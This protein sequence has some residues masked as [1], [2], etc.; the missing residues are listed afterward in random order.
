MCLGKW[1]DHF[2]GTEQSSNWLFTASIFLLDRERTYQTISSFPRKIEKWP[3]SSLKLL[4]VITCAEFQKIRVQF[5]RISIQCHGTSTCVKPGKFFTRTLLVLH[6]FQTILNPL[7]VVLEYTDLVFPFFIRLWTNMHLS[8][9][10]DWIWIHMHFCCGSLDHFLMIQNQ[11]QLRREV[12]SYHHSSC[13]NFKWIFNDQPQ[14]EIDQRLNLYE[15][16]FLPC[17][18]ILDILQAKMN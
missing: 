3:V 18:G 17:D 2:V 8:L 7:F 10:H 9:T 15:D 11:Y 12:T 13:Q 14:I 1:D 4:C 6:Q 5:A 16:A